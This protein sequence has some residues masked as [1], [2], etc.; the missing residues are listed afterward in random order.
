MPAV[1]ARAFIR[2]NLRDEHDRIAM[3]N[4]S[5]PFFSRAGSRKS[6]IEF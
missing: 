1:H 2:L 4:N 5:S 6:P 3:I